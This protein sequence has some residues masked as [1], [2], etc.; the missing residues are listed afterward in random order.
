MGSIPFLSKVFA[1][2]RDMMETWFF[3]EIAFANR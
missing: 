3:L 2:S 1:K